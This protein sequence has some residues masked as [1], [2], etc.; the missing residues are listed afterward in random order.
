MRESNYPDKKLARR[1]LNSGDDGFLLQLLPL[2]SFLAGY[3]PLF[4]LAMMLINIL[5]GKLSV[6]TN[7]HIARAISGHKLL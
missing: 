2:Y 1:C 6:P 3:H 5:Q 7:L 4:G